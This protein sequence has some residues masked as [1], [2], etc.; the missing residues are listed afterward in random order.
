MCGIYSETGFS[1][2]A[3]EFYRKLFS[4]E[5]FPVL[6]NEISILREE[7]EAIEAE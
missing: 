7:T 4:D 6:E 5:E 2:G 3:V 1:Q